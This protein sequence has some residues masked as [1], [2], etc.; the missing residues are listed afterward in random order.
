M[1]KKLWSDGAAVIESAA[2]ESV[3]DAAAP[4]VAELEVGP[5]I[6]VAPS[7]AEPGPTQPGPQA[8]PPLPSETLPPLPERRRPSRHLPNGRRRWNPSRRC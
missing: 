2:L 6:V 4:A 8:S 5:A 3:V 1:L 7:E